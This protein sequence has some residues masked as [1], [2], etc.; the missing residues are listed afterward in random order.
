MDSIGADELVELVSSLRR[1]GGEPT[2]VEAKSG[3]GGFPKS[4]R[5]SLVAFA[6]TSGGTV[7]IGVEE[8]TGFQVV[9]IDDI[10]AYR[11]Q[12]VSLSRDAITPPLQIETEIIEFEGKQILVAHVPPST[13]D[14]RPVYVTSKGVSTGADI[15][16]GDGDRRMTEAEIALVYSSR[17]QPTYDR[18]SVEGAT[19][20]DLD[21]P[22][23][24]R[25]LERVRLGSAALRDSD[26]AVALY[27]LGI[28]AE[29]ALDSQPTLAG[30]LAYGAFP[31]QFFPQ[32]MISVVVLASDS[33]GDSRF[34]DNV[35]V[36]GSLPEMVSEALAVVRRNLAARAVVVDAGRTDHLDYPLDAI[37]EAVVNAVL[38]RDYSPTTRGTQIQVE[39][40]GEALVVRSPGGLFGALTEDDLGTI[41]ISSSRNSVLANLLSDTYLPRSEQ[42][43][44]ENRASGIPTM[45]ERARARGLP[46]PVFDSSVTTF[47]VTMSRSALLGPNVKNWLA[48]LDIAL[49]T[50]AHEIAVAMMR[51]GFVTNAAMRE[52]GADRLAAGQVLRDL[53]ESGV[54]VRQGGRRYARY[55][56]DPSV[57][58]R[59]VSDNGVGRRR[60][61][62]EEVLSQLGEAGA[63]ELTERTGISRVAVVK[64]LNAL[65]EGGM[66]RADGRPRS[67]KRTYVWLGRKAE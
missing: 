36:R 37:R 3:A 34:L 60:Q 13:A 32:L 41:G 12:L 8:D 57:T 6:N 47:T 44:A 21:K 61:S 64:Q 45:I 30:L 20:A 1:I 11:D 23:V 53:V 4:V 33:D 48:S 19:Y 65:I 42:L 54:A 22:A 16:T 39:L 7:V 14:H 24:L 43:V 9:D 15:R 55:V 62:V 56:L 46:R 28:L 17:T 63:R 31:Q 26:D 18:E 59:A 50:P 27:R 58:K 35:T 25:T 2:T 40:S 5:E 51:G 49:P 10:A 52:W 66:V 67:P 38:H 29:P